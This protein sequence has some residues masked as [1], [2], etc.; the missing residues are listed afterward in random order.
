M[1]PSTRNIQYHS[2]WPSLQKT[3]AQPVRVRKDGVFVLRIACDSVVIEKDCLLWC[4][5]SPQ[6]P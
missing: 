1:L 6:K 2:G 4:L 3:I 5:T